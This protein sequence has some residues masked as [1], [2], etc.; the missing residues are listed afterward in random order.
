MIRSKRPAKRWG[1]VIRRVSPPT[2]F[3]LIEM[4][5]VIA[6]ISILAAMLSSALARAKGLALSTY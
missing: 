4:L 2:A 6:F 5:V 3:T 1:A